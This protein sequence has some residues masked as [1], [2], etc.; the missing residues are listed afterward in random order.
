MGGEVNISLSLAMIFTIQSK[1]TI[2]SSMSL[3]FT[4]MRNFLGRFGNF[5]CGKAERMPFCSFSKE[6]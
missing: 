4:N 6:A 5:S 3:S 2:L 1:E